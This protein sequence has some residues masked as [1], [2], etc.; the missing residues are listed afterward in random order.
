MRRM[1]E[2]HLEHPFAGARMLRGLLG[3]DAIRSAAITWPGR[4]EWELKRLSREEHQPAA[5]LAYRVSVPAAA[6]EDRPAQS[7]LDHRYHLMN[8]LF[9]FRI[10]SD[11][12]GAP[13]TVVSGG[14][15]ATIL[16]CAWDGRNN[17]Y[18][19]IRRRFLRLRSAG[20][21][22]GQRRAFGSS[23]RGSGRSSR[24]S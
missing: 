10:E 2:L 21:D 20:S 16:C 15:H 9:S 12:L 5:S 17:Y 24:R 22:W 11:N 4:C 23:Q 18:E 8:R 7:G 13:V 14:I 6:S 3:Q 1:Y 19:K